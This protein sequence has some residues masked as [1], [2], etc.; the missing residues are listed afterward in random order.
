MC[1]W[2]NFTRISN[3]NNIDKYSV[4]VHRKS[5]ITGTTAFDAAVVEDLPPGSFS[6]ASDHIR[7]VDWISGVKRS[8]TIRQ[9]SEQMPSEW[10]ELGW[11]VHHFISPHLAAYS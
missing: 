1:R 5:L 10:S 11:Q 8:N 4:L 3:A 6:D 7:S 2:R 9:R